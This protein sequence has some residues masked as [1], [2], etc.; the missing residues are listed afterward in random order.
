MSEIV[1]IPLEDLARLTGKK[2]VELKSELFDANGEEITQKESALEAIA[3]LFNRKFTAIK[4]ENH[5]KG[6]RKAMQTVE[7]YV[8]SKGF[9]PDTEMQGTDLIDAW[10]ATLQKSEPGKGSKLTAEELEANEVAQKWLNDKA[11]T[12]KDGYEGKVKELTK[13]LSEK[14]TSI[15]RN[16]A[17]KAAISALDDAKWNTGEPE[18]RKIRESTIKDLVD[19]RIAASRIRPG[20]TE[21]EI[22][23]FDEAGQPAK[24]ATFNL[25]SYEDFVKSINP[26]GF[27]KFDPEKKSPSPNP[28]PGK[29]GDTKPKIVIR[30][31]AHYDELRK[32]RNQERDPAKRQ[33]LV[34]ELQEA[35]IAQRPA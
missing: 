25:I 2:A 32:Q 30:D 18:D 12:M 35:W 24:D 22:L 28:Q 6:L 34:K 13:K 9:T 1:S 5:G 27:H 8:K 33:A 17:H 14:E 20:A 7:D 4:D 10:A 15:F 3:S 21:D 16:T 29:P 26:F 31:Q 11:K 19:M 23:V